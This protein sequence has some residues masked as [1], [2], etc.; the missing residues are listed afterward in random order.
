MAKKRSRVEKNPVAGGRPAYDEAPVQ[1][2][3]RAPG[4]STGQS[5]DLLNQQRGAPMAREAELGTDVSQTQ[6]AAPINLPDAFGPGGGSIPVSSSQPAVGP[7]LSMSNGLTRDDVDLLLE[8][9]N[10]IV[11]S[12][13]TAALTRRGQVARQEPN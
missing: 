5:Q 1:N 11:P 3:P 13:E 4:D 7:A 9:I 12:Y 10:A 6:S 8:E 2:I